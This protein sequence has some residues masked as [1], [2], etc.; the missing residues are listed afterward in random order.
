MI[1]HGIL[2]NDKIRFFRFLIRDHGGRKI[3]IDFC[4]RAEFSDSFYIN[5][6]SASDRSENLLDSKTVPEQSKTPEQETSDAG[7]KPPETR[8]KKRIITS[9][10]VKEVADE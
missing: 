5:K 3:G 10:G 6:I 7:Q 2:T 1:I 8:P 4:F 9:S